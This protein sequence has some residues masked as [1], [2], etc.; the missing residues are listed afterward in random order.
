MARQKKPITE[1]K[2]FEINGKPFIWTLQD[3]VQV[4]EAYKGYC[5]DHGKIFSVYN[6]NGTFEEKAPLQKRREQKTIVSE[7]S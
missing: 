6:N 2:P 7:R 4:V 5:K 3:H 1:I